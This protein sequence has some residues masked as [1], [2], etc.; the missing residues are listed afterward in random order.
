MSLVDKLALARD[1]VPRAHGA[2]CRRRDDDAGHSVDGDGAHVARVASEDAKAVALLARDGPQAGGGVLA[3]RN[4]E[5]K[6]KS[7]PVD[8]DFG[9]YKLSWFFN[10]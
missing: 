10:N 2:V 3:A 7:R 8:K 6:S 5:V 1:G 4:L 9:G